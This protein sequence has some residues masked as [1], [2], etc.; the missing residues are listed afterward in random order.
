LEADELFHTESAEQVAARLASDPAEGLNAGE[1]A[2]RLA[3]VGPNELQRVGARSWLMVL[4]AQFVDFLIV[5]LLVAAGI[6]LAIGQTTDAL[7]ILA[8]VLINGLVGFVQEWRAEKSLDALQRMLALKTQV[9]RNG[10][11][12]CIDARLLVPGDLVR[13]DI[14]DQIPADMRLTK[15]VE[16]RIDESTLTGESLPVDK[17][18]E[19]VPE[20]I[21][22]ANRSCMAWMGSSVVNGNGEGLVVATAM[23]TEFGQIARLTQSV[24]DQRTPLQARLGNLGKKL[25]VISLGLSAAI[26]LL[27]WALGRPLLEMFFTGVALAVAVV[28]EALPIV[29]TTTLALGIGAMVK[30]RALFRRLPAAETLGSTT[31]ICSDK[32]GTITSNQMTVTAI[33]MLAGSVEV[34]GEGYDPTGQF[35]VDGTAV[36]PASRADLAALLTTAGLC[37]NAQVQKTDA[38]W[39]PVGGSTEAALLVAALKG[40]CGPPENQSRAGELA[41]NSERKR[42]TVVINAGDQLVAHTKGAPEA[43]VPLCNRIRRGEEV[44]PLDADTLKQ[45][46]TAYQ[47]MAQDGQRVLALAATELPEGS[48]IDAPTVE[49]DMVF[50]GLAGIIDPPR[51]EVKQA[52][53]IARQAGIRVILITGDAGE[54]ATAIAESIGLPDSVT[55]TGPAVQAMDDT[56]LTEALRGEVLF[57]RTTP[58]QK[59]RI[60]KLLQQN[61][62]VVAMTGDGVNDAPA[63]QKADIGVAMGIRGTDVARSA[64]DLILLDDNFSS[65]VA[66]VAEGRRQFDNIRKFVQYILSANL[67][68]VLA[69]L[70]NIVLGGPLI[71]LPVQILWMNLVTDGMTVAAVGTYV[72]IAAVALFYFNLGAGTDAEVMRAQTLA[73][74]GIIVLEK[75]NVLNFRSLNEPLHVIGWFSNKW[76]LVVIAITLGVHT[77][78]IYVPFLQQALHTVPLR[79]ED[80]LL[81]LIVALPLL[82]V[83]ELRKWRMAKQ[84]AA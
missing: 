51:A 70:A 25:G 1:A 77:C 2:K 3:E 47:G 79:W 64:A 35:S 58:E 44:V 37:N 57:A 29:V 76:L 7:T 20:N 28:P 26:A 63:L 19:A 80:W 24:A 82:G 32:T 41:F 31:V 62:E 74:T 71:L 69:I 72:A 67:G 50:L 34:S 73:F 60:V 11:E 14:G 66:A 10:V 15:A 65:I 40:R 9:V 12:T 45:I 53:S 49:A 68:E 83:M 4:G 81:L 33:W 48:P 42:M 61:G 84:S 30:K 55:L 18:I 78:A 22:L 39:Q 23:T 17:T 75:I 54:T 56:Q 21:P 16:L 59:L 6:S 43:I 8:V 27:G 13:L 36:D 46:E 38:G 52:I 5:I